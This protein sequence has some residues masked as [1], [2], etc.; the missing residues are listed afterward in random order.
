VRRAEQR[1]GFPAVLLQVF[2]TYSSGINEKIRLPWVLS[3][4]IHSDGRTDEEAADRHAT[5][6]L[7]VQSYMR[8]LRN[9][10]SIFV[11]ETVRSLNSIL[12]YTYHIHGDVGAGD[13]SLSNDCQLEP[14][15]WA[16]DDVSA[17]V[18]RPHSRVDGEHRNREKCT[19]A[20]KI[21]IIIII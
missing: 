17:A 3:F 6:G 5:D 9:A 15:S 2:P 12:L 4:Q 19:R 14:Q 7:T 10:Q 1:C 11:S 21:I 16:E 8:R 20:L 18:C 13:V